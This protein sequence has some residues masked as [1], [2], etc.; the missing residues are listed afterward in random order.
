[1]RKQ[2]IKA[3]SKAYLAM[4]IKKLSLLLLGTYLLAFGIAMIVRANIGAD[5]WTTF[6]I[7]WH[8]FSGL[9]IGEVNQIFALVIL[10]IN[11][12][13][14]K[15]KVGIGSILNVILIGPFIDVSISI[16]SLPFDLLW[17][18]MLFVGIGTAIESFGVALYV[19]ASAGAGPIDG[20]T[21]I[22]S[23]KTKTSI[24]M[25][26]IIMDII[27]LAMGW[28]LGATVGIGT[29]IG[30]AIEGPFIE[31]FLNTYG[32]NISQWVKSTQ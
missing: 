16:L 8:K 19:S 24:K 27:A 22:L 21:L 17:G 18:K 11:Y 25:V 12:L 5:P 20:L 32:K 10:T 3:V 14:D 15:K 1:M 30:S 26:R 6:M 4:W 31:F 2:Q 28:L 13:T 7:G 29:I 23:K 9:T